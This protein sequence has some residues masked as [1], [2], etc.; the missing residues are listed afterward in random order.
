MTTYRDR[1]LAG[2]YAPEDTED[3]LARHHITSHELMGTPE[4]E[5][6]PEPDDPDTE[7]KT[8]RRKTT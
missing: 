7:E 8:R 6:E 4:P 3:L 5:P 2:D 1:L